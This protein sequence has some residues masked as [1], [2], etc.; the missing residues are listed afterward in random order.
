MPLL[1][2]YTISLL[3][4]EKI[5]IDFADPM[6]SEYELNYLLSFFR[7][8]KKEIYVEHQG[9]IIDYIVTP[10]RYWVEFLLELGFDDMAHAIGE[11]LNDLELDRIPTMKEYIDQLKHAK[12]IKEL[13]KEK[14]MEKDERRFEE[15][16]KEEIE[17]LISN[18][19]KF[20]FPEKNISEIAFEKDLLKLLEKCEGMFVAYIKDAIVGFDAEEDV[21]IENVLFEKG[22]KP[23][24]IKKIEEKVESE[25]ES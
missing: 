21:L 20:T 24:L 9:R 5:A 18:K 19:K 17:R 3:D 12:P 23:D 15:M 1:V 2:E 10:W 7:K 22:R 4:N 8:Y 11:I 13:K 16:K 6:P 25:V 14:I